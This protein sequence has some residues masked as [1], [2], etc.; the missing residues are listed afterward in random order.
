M[1]PNFSILKEIPK[2]LDVKSVDRAVQ[3]F[4]KD[5]HCIDNKIGLA[6]QTI[7][8][9]ARSVLTNCKD[10]FFW[11]V[12]D[13][14]E[15]TGYVLTHLSKD[16][17][18]SLCYYMTQAWLH[19]KYRHSLFAKNCLQKLREHAKDLGCKHIIIPSSR[20][21]NGYLRWLGKQWHVYVT[22]LKEDI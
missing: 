8:N 16:V 6:N 11:G 14:N 5:S 12:I 18:D 21:T 20:G 10:Q 19:P 2:D 15:L 13:N 3:E 17:D 22:L 1:F 9:I 4:T 7:E